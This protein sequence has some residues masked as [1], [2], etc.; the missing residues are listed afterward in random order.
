VAFAPGDRVH[1]PGIG[2]G[3]VREVRNASRYLVEVK[4]RTIIVAAAQL[5]RASEKGGRAQARMQTVVRAPVPEAEPASRV[6]ALDL[7]GRTV[8]ESIEALDSFLNDALLAG[9]ATVHVIHGR[10]GGRVRAAVHARLASLPSIRGFRL[11]PRNP[12]ATIVTL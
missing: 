4:G 12:G 5:V 7:H 8:P 10:S 11:D 9:H 1:I 2:T 6:P 3:V